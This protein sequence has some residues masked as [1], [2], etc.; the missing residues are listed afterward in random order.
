[1]KVTAVVPIKLNNE[2]LPG[3]NLKMLGD[4]PLIQYILHTLTSI[5]LINSVYVYCSDERI[6]DFLPPQVR[7]LKRPE[8]LDLPSSNFNQ[9][10]DSFISEV[11]S[12][13]Y[14]YTHATAPFLRAETIVECIEEVKRGKYDSAFTVSKIQDFL[15]MNG[16]PLNFDVSDTPR[17][18]DLPPIY[19]ETSGVYVFTRES[20]VATHARIGKHPYMKEVSFRESVDINNPEDFELAEKL[21][22]M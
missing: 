1:M 15:W 5:P 2:R 11:E 3:K 22:N 16:E 9:I 19:R 6:C 8:F 12:E 18:Q 13:I 20:Y 14:V 7:F 10:F 4:R 17:S 21:L